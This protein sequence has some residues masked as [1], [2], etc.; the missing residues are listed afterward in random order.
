MTRVTVRRKPT[1]HHVCMQTSL[2]GMMA[3][4]T[5]AVLVLASWASALEELLTGLDAQKQRAD[6]AERLHKPVAH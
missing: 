2:R 4:A 1:G 3:L 6:L 5:L